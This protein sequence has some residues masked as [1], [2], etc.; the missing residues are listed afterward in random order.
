MTSGVRQRIGQIETRT[1]PLARATVRVAAILTMAGIVTGCG[2]DHNRGASAS[3]TRTTAGNLMHLPKTITRLA[4]LRVNR[5][6]V[7]YI[8]AAHCSEQE[9]DCY[10]LGEEMEAPV[11]IGNR[12]FERL[13]VV[14]TGPS[15]NNG[16]PAERILFGLHAREECTGSTPFTVAYG[17]LQA[18]RDTVLVR[19]GGKRDLAFREAWIPSYMHPRGV[20]A[21]ALIP[22]GSREVIVRAPSGRIVSHQEGSLTRTA[23]SCT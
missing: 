10:R 8:T 5:D 15:I 6:T 20:L 22:P 9:T 7:F 11:R 16:G 14:G 13:N 1:L 2:A 18:A 3:A 4:T 17:M 23:S 21:Y 19:S 12:T